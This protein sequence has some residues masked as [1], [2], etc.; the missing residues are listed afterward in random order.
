MDDRSRSDSVFRTTLLGRMPSFGPPVAPIGPWRSIVL[1][2]RDGVRAV[3]MQ[4]VT[5]EELGVVSARLRVQ[6]LAGRKVSSARL[7]VGG[8]Q[9]ALRCELDEAGAV[10]L[11]GT[12][13][14]RDAEPWWPHTHGPQPLYE[15]TVVLQLG[16]Q[17]IG[18]RGGPLGFRQLALHT[19]AGDDFALHINGTSIFCRGACWTVSDIFTLSGNARTLE[20]DLTL[21]RDAGL[22]VHQAGYRLSTAGVVNMF[23]HTAHVESIAVFERAD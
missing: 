14:L 17:E 18:V 3:E 22:L 23:A 16:A 13:R 7:I 12:L 5:G 11:S 21:A 15:P 8:E 9:A 19:G 10:Q 6:P 4:L 2:Q 1:E 20:R